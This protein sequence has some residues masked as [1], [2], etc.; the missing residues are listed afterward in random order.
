RQTL[1]DFAIPTESLFDNFYV[2]KFVR[3]DR[4]SGDPVFDLTF[5][6][7]LDDTSRNRIWIDKTQRYITR[8]EWYG[9]E[10]QLRAIFLYEQPKTVDGVTFPTQLTVRNAENN[11]AG[12]T[13]YSNVKGNRGIADAVFKL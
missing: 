3:F 13:R 1:L 7:T 2:A 8:R 11:V 9:Q 10:G 6:K 5:P 4:A 12:V